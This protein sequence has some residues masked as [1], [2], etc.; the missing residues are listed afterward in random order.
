MSAPQNITN[1]RY[2]KL[3]ALR[4]V[5][6]TPNGIVWELRCD[7]GVTLYR[8]VGWLNY[9]AGKALMCASCRSKRQARRAE[10][11]R[12]K[13]TR[14]LRKMWAKHG[15]LYSADWEQREEQGIL[16][17]LEA[18]ICPTDTRLS[19]S[20]AQI[21]NSLAEPDTNP[22]RH[23]KAAY[24]YPLWNDGGELEWPCVECEEIG[25]VRFGCIRC[26]NAV[27]PECVEQ[28]KHSCG[29]LDKGSAGH[30]TLA[31]IGA[32]IG[33]TRQ[34]VNQ[35]ETRA[36]GKFREALRLERVRARRE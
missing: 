16:E 32:A 31:D 17:E 1:K 11:R 35:V 28:E 30:A 20:E 18:T 25:E 36:I 12:S 10:A 22:Q 15:S 13:L 24:L 26:L 33:T 14:V 9:H 2:G 5:E 23:Q 4:P 7:C 27:C 34:Y 8:T 6:S 19:A 3:T 21:D 29:H